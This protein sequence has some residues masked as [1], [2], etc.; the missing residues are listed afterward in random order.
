MAGKAARVIWGFD[1]HGQEHDPRAVSVW[2]QAVEIFK[3]DTTILGGDIIDNQAFSAHAETKIE[4]KKGANTLKQELAWGCALID[5]VQNH[6]AGKVVF[7]EGNHDAWV[8]RFCAQL[9]QSL[10]CALESM[11]SPRAAF[12]QNGKRKNF[13]W[14]PYRNL[15]GS[16]KNEYELPHGL[17]TVH[18][19]STATAAATAHL[20]KYHYCKSVVFGHS[21]RYE[22][23]GLQLPNRRF[24]EAMNPGCLCKLRPTYA[25]GPTNWSQGFCVA[26]IGRRSYTLHRVKITNGY[27]VMPDGTEIHA[28]KGGL[29]K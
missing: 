7:I 22:A 10:A 12:T 11:V 26:Y 13:I 19:M 1:F 3:P 17:V 14:V 18:G 6:T 2:Q 28:K 25:D 21:H 29:R 4:G 9:P 20:K 27:A 5:H 16:R 24:V 15:K 8:E 23:Q